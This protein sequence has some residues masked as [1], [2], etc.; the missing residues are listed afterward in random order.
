MLFNRKS[1]NMPF[2]PSRFRVIQ[3]TALSL[4]ECDPWRNRPVWGQPMDE[5]K[6][7]SGIEKLAVA[8]QQAGFSIEQMIGL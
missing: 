5:G 2:S 1:E 8:G 3:I 7:L 4:S 6:L